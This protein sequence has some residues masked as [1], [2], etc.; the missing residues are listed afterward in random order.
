MIRSIML[1]A[2]AMAL[3]L[4]F[5]AATQAEQSTP[6]AIKSA[7]IAGEW[8]FVAN[9]G[10]ECTFSGTALL[11]E[12]D[13]PGRYGCE[14]TAVQV[15]VVDTWQ[16]RQSCAASRVGDEVVIVSRIEEYI[17]GTDSGSYRP[18]NFKLTIKSADLMKGVLIS[19]GY[20]LAEFRRSEGST[21]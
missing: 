2:C 21:S 6:D 11:L 9:T 1:G 5:T 19:W 16:V 10:P 7:N 15:C 12:T 17:Q 4:G 20:H 8:S 3:S 14:L 13:E 18:D